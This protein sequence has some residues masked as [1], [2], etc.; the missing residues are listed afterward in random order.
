MAKDD[1]RK[2][3]FKARLTRAS[4]SD[5]P[6]EEIATFV[7]DPHPRVRAE[8]AA[9]Q[10]LAE[11]ALRDLAR[12]RE[13]IVRWGVVLNPTI[14]TRLLALL[15]SDPVEFIRREVARHPATPA[16]TLDQ[17]ANDHVLDVRLAVASNPKT[18]WRTLQRMVFTKSKRIARAV[19]NHPNTPRDHPLKQLVKL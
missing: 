12:D 18:E 19:A 17:L 14:S 8:A 5:A 1:D 9:H 4:S 10:Y 2:K 15:A 16:E 6:P 3:Q 11:A 7:N 13:Y